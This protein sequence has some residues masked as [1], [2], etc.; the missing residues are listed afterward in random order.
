MLHAILTSLLI[1]LVVVIINRLSPGLLQ[2]LWQ[3]TLRVSWRVLKFLL[4]LGLIIYIVVA[5]YDSYEQRQR[6][7][8]ERQEL[9]DYTERLQALKEQQARNQ[10]ET[11]DQGRELQ[12]AHSEIAKTQSYNVVF[13]QQ[14]IQAQ[15]RQDQME[16]N[17][18]LAAMENNDL[19][20]ARQQTIVDKLSTR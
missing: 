18:I 9:Q 19:Y 12:R 5:V 20:I 2:D 8:R 4:V 7:A 14:L 13:A 3:A 15:Q 1:I 6:Q 11:L 10:S 16:V 17:R